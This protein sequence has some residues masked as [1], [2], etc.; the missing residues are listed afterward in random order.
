M[1]NR[2]DYTIELRNGVRCAIQALKKLE[3]LDPDELSEARGALLHLADEL[4]D[5]LRQRYVGLDED[6]EAEEE[7]ARQGF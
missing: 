5:V 6:V 4:E 1:L 3:G 7:A 2:D